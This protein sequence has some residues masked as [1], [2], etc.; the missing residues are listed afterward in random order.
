MALDRIMNMKSEIDANL[1]KLPEK[2]YV[3][4]RIQCSGPHGIPPV[5]CI[6]RGEDGYYP[7]YTSA[8]AAQLN[9]NLGVTPQQAEAMF[10]GSLFG[11]YTPAADPDN[12]INSKGPDA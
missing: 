7:V 4:N 6:K 1:A 3:A 10:N 11:W 2:A 12:P 8:T 9:E 5:L